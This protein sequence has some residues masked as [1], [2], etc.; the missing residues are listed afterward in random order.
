LAS[1][2]NCQKGGKW[3]EFVLIAQGGVPAAVVGGMGVVKARCLFLTFDSWQVPDHLYFITASICGWKQLFTNPTYSGIVLNSLAWLRKEKRMF[4]YAFVLMPSHL[5]AIVLP[6]N[7]PIGELLQTFASFTAHAILH[8]LQRD[9]RQE[10]LAFF[11]EQRRD[12]RAE[13]SIWQDVQA[14][15]IF[16]EDFLSQKMEYI[17][18]NPVAKEWSLANDRAEYKFSSA[19]FYDEDRQPI[20]GIDDIREWLK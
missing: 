20:I 14:K 3:R 13:H 2:A 16:T 9:G 10:L 17:H 15:N 6:I 18:Q 19:C 7:E 5:H 8:Q 4:L 11:H 12:R 1:S